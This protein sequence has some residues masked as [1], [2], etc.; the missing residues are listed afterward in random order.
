MVGCKVQRHK[1][2]YWLY[3]VRLKDFIF[4]ELDAVYFLNIIL[5]PADYADFS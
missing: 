4:D 3:V 1:R 5:S 2:L